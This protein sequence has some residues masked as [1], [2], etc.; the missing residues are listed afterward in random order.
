MSRDYKNSPP[1]FRPKHA[2]APA[3][4]KSRS[5]IPGLVIGLF[6]GA[7]VAVGVAFFINTQ[8][9]PFQDPAA[10]KKENSSAAEEV[11]ILNPPGVRVAGG[12]E[13][14]PEQTPPPLNTEHVGASEALPEKTPETAPEPPPAEPEKPLDYEFYK[15]LPGE[16]APQ[17]ELDVR[18]EKLSTKA[19]TPTVLDGA[20]QTPAE[21]PRVE[22]APTAP[23]K[24][25]PAKTRRIYLQFASFSRAGEA[26][27][28]KAKLLLSGVDAHIQQAE[29]TG[30][31]LMHRVRVG[32]FTREADAERVRAQLN[33]QQGLTSTI[34]RD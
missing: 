23:V 28:L 27:N 6:L 11:T 8:K 30:R 33:A 3:K 2:P 17:G 13:S 34:V 4:T 29:V 15:I 10:K 22:P 20:S 21:T 12:D 7:L 25:E 9:S 19:E 16:D 31:G 24:T 18:Q 32:P 5:M 26:D 14:A 1:P